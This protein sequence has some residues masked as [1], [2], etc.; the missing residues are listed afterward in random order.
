MHKHSL[1]QLVSKRAAKHLR[2]FRADVE[3]RF[4]TRVKSIK[5]FGSRARGD[6]KSNSDY[7]VVVFIENDESRR[8]TDHILSDLAYPHVLAG[9]DIQAFSVPPDFLD[10]PRS[11][12][13]AISVQEEG[14]E[15]R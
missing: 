15:L 3:K 5:L 8:A 9:V 11:L 7:D 4:G 10:R 12:P 13:L 1:D 6:A 2:S 14:I